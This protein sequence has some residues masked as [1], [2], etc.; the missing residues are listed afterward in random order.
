MPRGKKIKS[1]S[2]LNETFLSHVKIGTVH[3]CWEWMAGKRGYAEYGSFRAAAR[4]GLASSPHRFIWEAITKEKLGSNE[5]DHMCRNT[6]CVNP[7]H[8]QRVPKGWNAK[9]GLTSPA[10]IRIKK[11]HCHRG[12]P[13]TPNNVNKWGT[14]KT[15]DNTRTRERYRAKVAKA[16][17]G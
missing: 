14:C 12:H 2:E 5:I 7:N 15:C 1:L 4:W 9:Q 3:V 13:R 8:L 10:R 11:S 6:S 17:M 16:R